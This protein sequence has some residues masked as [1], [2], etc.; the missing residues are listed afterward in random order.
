MKPPSSKPSSN[1]SIAY[2]RTYFDPRC[3]IVNIPCRQISR[4]RLHKRL[5]CRDKTPRKQLQRQPPLRSDILQRDIRGYFRHHNTS[6]EQLRADIH[7]VRGDPEIGGDGRREHGADV[8]A[9]H[10]Q[11]EKCETKDGEQDEVDSR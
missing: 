10:L 8:H 11:G 2:Q 3:P 7:L 6:R 4:I 9:I 5:K 1:L